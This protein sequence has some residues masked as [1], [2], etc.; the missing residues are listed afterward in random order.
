M[1]AEV[2]EARPPTDGSGR[3]A[4][5][6]M[7]AVLGL[8]TLVS[9]G[10]ASD[11][12]NGGDSDAGVSTPRPRAIFN[13]AVH[14][15]D[16]PE[17]ESRW[18]AGEPITAE[19]WGPPGVNPNRDYSL[20]FITLITNAGARYTFTT[21]LPAVVLRVVSASI[22]RVDSVFPGPEVQPPPVT[23]QRPGAG[24]LDARREGAPGEALRRYA[25]RLDESYARL[26]GNGRPHLSELYKAVEGAALAACR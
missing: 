3:E 26:F 19:C 9:C 15:A 23:T 20:S 22:R 25:E 10:F 6:V 24:P 18:P 16:F 8:L 1:K 17:S 2:E 14:P 21:S 11:D 5:R 7:L 4:M 13:L 12:R